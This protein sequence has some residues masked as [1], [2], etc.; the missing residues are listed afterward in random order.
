MPDVMLPIPEIGRNDKE[1][2]RNLTD[3]VVKLRKELEFLLQN[4]DEQ[5]V[6]KAQ[7]AVISDLLAGTITANQ[8]DVTEGKI[9]AAQIEDLVVG[10]NVTMGSDA[11]ISW[12]QVTGTPVIPVLPD[13]I[14]YT[15]IDATNVISPNITGGIITG[16]LIRTT[17]EN[18]R[19]MELS[20]SGLITY[21][22]SN[23][24]SGVSIVHGSAYFDSS[25]YFY[26]SGVNYA[27]IWYDLGRFNIITNGVPVVF[28]S[29]AGVYI[30]DTTN[31]NNKVA[32]KGDISNLG[33]ATESFVYTT[34]YTAITAHVQQYHS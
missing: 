3:T 26:Q 34:V 29:S 24:R 2:I 17:E 23:Q 20:P 28:T 9:Q 16:A 13:Y 6:I 12:G 21:N 22:G 11:T 4:L 18:N 7:S 14:K 1:T 31:D 30:G 15:Y 10:S 5:N 8:I 25:I 27:G 19:R 33:F 32:T